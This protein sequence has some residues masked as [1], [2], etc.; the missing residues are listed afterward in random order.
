MR[1]KI[2]INI[3]DLLVAVVLVTALCVICISKYTSA[4]SESN[5]TKMMNITFYA[6]EVSDSIA[7]SIKDG[8]IVSDSITNVNF[9]PCKDIMIGDSASY[10]ST[11]DNTFVKVNRAGYKSVELTCT[12][13]G[14]YSDIGAVYNNEIYGVGHTLTIF[15]GDTRITARVKNIEVVGE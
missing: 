1:R 11:S 12:A 5:K 10:I 9:G 4:S 7:E 13:E 15:V 8:D 14:I 3:I 6:E 2:K